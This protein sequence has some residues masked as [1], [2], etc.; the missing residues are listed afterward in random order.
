M[1]AAWWFGIAIAV[2]LILF[3]AVVGASITVERGMSAAQW[4]VLVIIGLPTLFIAGVGA[5]LTYVRVTTMGRSVREALPTDILL[6]VILIA[7]AIA[8]IV[9]GVIPIG[10]AI[11]DRF[12]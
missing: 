10:E 6:V 7:D 9:F 4:I 1:S 5:V 11:Y 3:I 2:L 12:F 8:V